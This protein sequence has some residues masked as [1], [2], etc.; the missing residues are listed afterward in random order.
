MILILN[1][2]DLTEGSERVPLAEMARDMERHDGTKILGPPG[3]YVIRRVQHLS[4]IFVRGRNYIV[5]KDGRINPRFPLDGY[6][7]R[8]MHTL[9]NVLTE[10]TGQYANHD[11]RQHVALS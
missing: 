2:N 9:V 10:I 3:H 8:S 5:L 11:R 1:D 6:Y 7:V 4:I